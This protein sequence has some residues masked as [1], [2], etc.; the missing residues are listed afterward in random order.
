[1]TPGDDYA[2]IG[3]AVARRFG[4]R[5]AKEMPLP[6]VLLIDGGP[7]QLDAAAAA[8]GTAE[9]QLPLMIGVAKGSSRKPGLEQLFLPGQDEALRLDNDDPALLLIQQVRDEAHR[10][11]IAGHRGRRAKARTRSEL[12]E[13]SGLGPARRQSLLRNFGG[14]RQLRRASLADLEKVPGIHRALAKRVYDYLHEND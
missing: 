9:V 10:F 14:M 1:M 3:Q 13:I 12:E 5:L 7:G 11:A 2:A 6:D 4:G 8:L